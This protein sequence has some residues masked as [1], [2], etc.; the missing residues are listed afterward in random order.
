M[1]K[2]VPS[3]SLPRALA[4]AERV[5]IPAA[6]GEGLVWRW[7]ALHRSRSPRTFETDVFVSFLEAIIAPTLVV[8]GATSTLVVTDI[9]QRLKALEPAEQCILDGGHNLHHDTP[10]ALSKAIGAFLNGEPT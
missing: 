9:A 4:L 3:L 10:K 5:T 8:Q 7:D 2:S 1:R 6:Q